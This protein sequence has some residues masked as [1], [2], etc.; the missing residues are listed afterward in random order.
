MR[1]TK[2]RLHTWFGSDLLS[3]VGSSSSK[4]SLAI[5]EIGGSLGAPDA[6]DVSLSSISG[7]CVA[8]NKASVSAA[9][10]LGRGT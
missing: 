2:G 3:L 1:S 8:V 10:W 9:W 7:I 5:D 4:M 6:F